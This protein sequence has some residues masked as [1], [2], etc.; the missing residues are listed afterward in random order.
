MQTQ[1]DIHRHPIKSGEF[2]PQQKDPT[3]DIALPVE[4]L[5]QAQAE[6]A[7]FAEEFA[8]APE[9]TVVWSLASTA[10]RTQEAQFIFDMELKTI[11]R[12][13]KEETG[14]E[15]SIIDLQGNMPDK[16]VKDG[17][18]SAMTDD[19]QKMKVVLV[20]GP[21]T[22][23][24][25][26]GDYNLEQYEKLMDE[27]GSEEELI[28]R[29][30]EFDEVS[31]RINVDYGQVADGFEKLMGSIVQSQKNLFPDRNV[32]VK[33]FGHSA[34]VEV[35]LATWSKLSTKDILSLG[36]GGMVGF[37]ESARVEL[38]P[39]GN[40]SITYRNSQLLRLPKCI[41]AL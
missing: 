36:K 8:A 16:R 3:I 20:N 2:L 19:D 34:E 33:A 23:L 6:A 4:G 13:L 15:I 30:P 12:K 7:R 1:V 29:W 41:D 31:R 28:A 38:D 22:E 11:A 10:P 37:L 9:G 5:Q 17:I 40:Q 18:D 25:G 24:L 21:H 35:A 26:P 32:W 27:L 14:E 39:E